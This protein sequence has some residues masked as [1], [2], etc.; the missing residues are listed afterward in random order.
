MF[1]VWVWGLKLYIRDGVGVSEASLTQKP[2]TLNQNFTLNL[3]LF[4]EGV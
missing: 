1:G 3:N 2:K 4:I